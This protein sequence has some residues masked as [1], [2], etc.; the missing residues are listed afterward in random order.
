MKIAAFSGD[1]DFTSRER[2]RA[3]L[4]AL[5]D[6]GLTIVDLTN[7]SYMDSTA[8]AELILLHRKRTRAGKSAP[9]IVVGQKVAR[10]FDVA[11]LQA[12]VELFATV[13]E[14]QAE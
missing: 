4:A 10:L 14:A 13:A 11:G 5:D 8:L 12:V 3:Q 2:F 9:R 7:V 6:S 1:I